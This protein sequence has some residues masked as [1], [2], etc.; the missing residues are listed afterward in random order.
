ME[1]KALI[2]KAIGFIQKNPRE[3]LSLQS[4]AENAGF[5][6]TY[7]DA[8]FKQHTG[9]TPVE[10]SR[11]YKLTRCALELRRTK[12]SILD[13]ALDFG[14]ANP[15]SFSRA[16]KGFYSITPSDYRD[17][18]AN[19]P[20][21]WQDLSGRIAISHFRNSHPE[22]KASDIELALDYCFTHNPVKYAEDIVGMTVA[23]T[24]ILTL[25]DPERLEDFLYVSDYNS[26]EPSVM[27]VCENEGDAVRYLKALEKGGATNFSM[28]R[29]S[30]TEWESFDAE[31][32]RSGFTCRRGYDMIYTYDS[33]T[34]PE[35]DDLTI[36]LLSVDDMTYIKAFKQA[37][38][39]A[40]CHVRAIQIAFDGKGNTGLVPVGAFENGELVCLAMPCLDHIR[41][42]KKYDIG[43]IFT[44]DRI[45]R[46]K[47]VDLMW[48]YVIDFCL[49]ENAI[50]G[51]ANACDD[52]SPLG[53]R[54]C[55]S[56]GLVKVAE[57]CIYGKIK[58]D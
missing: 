53:I 51:N 40:E 43:A 52:D 21:N 33:I 42:L 10:Y 48:R 56:L 28:R 13:I 34:V 18:Y 32:A 31:I 38:G 36:R 41:E 39:C 50:I 30:D 58:N 23:Q 16:F 20:V 54:V 4:I 22:F 6:L 24:E 12:R 19:R 57:N 46:E 7:F 29:S 1:N 17:K 44:L 27:L 11:I 26:A 2:D 5:S 15:E 25:G 35:Y 8:I 47:T 14:Y 49:K 3:N 45:N 9:Y 37:G 55:E